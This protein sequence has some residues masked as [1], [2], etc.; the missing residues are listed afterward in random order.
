[1]LL[2]G[3]GGIGSVWVQFGLSGGSF[4][5]YFWIYVWFSFSSVWFCWLSFGSV[6][7][8]FGVG[9][10]WVQFGFSLVQCWFCLVQVW[11]SLGLC[12]VLLDQFWYSVG[13]VGFSFGSVGSVLAQCWLALV[14][15]VKFR[16]SLVHG[17]FCWFKFGSV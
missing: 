12:V 9:S 10:V 11:L 8:H 7:V 16:L 6:L 3:V 14:L 17:W 2:L 13:S 5:T 15:L 1:M 4:E